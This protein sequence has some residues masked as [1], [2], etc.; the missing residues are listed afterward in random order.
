LTVAL[1]FAHQ[2]GR[3]F[4]YFFPEILILAAV[5]AVAWLG[6]WRRR[7]VEHVQPVTPAA[8]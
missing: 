2:D 1:T 4:L 3:F 7:G 8:A 5:G 6:R